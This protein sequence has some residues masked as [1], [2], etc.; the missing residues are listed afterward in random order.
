MFCRA[1][2]FAAAA[3]AAAGLLRTRGFNIY[4]SALM[5]VYR[6]RTS[7]SDVYYNRA[8]KVTVLDMTL[9]SLYRGGETS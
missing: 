8:L 3:A 9:N 2:A 1:V 6:V 5:C 7:I 4:L